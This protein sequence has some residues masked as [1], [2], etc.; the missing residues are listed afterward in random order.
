MV[1]LVKLAEQAKQRKKPVEK[2][3]AYGKKLNFSMCAD[4]S[5]DNKKIAKQTETNRNRQK[6]TEMESNGQKWTETDLNRKK[7]TGGE[8]KKTLEKLHGRSSYQDTTHNIS[9]DI[10]TYR[11]NWPR[12]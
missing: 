11:L 4:R 2:N 3:P 12:N 10:A 5:T 9:T 8:R 1:S 6:Q 7:G